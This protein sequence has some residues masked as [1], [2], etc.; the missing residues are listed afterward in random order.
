MNIS[1]PFTP[2][3]GI[4]DEQNITLLPK[5]YDECGNLEYNTNTHGCCNTSTFALPTQFC[6]GGTIYSKCGGSDYDPA[7]Q[8]CSAQDSE[9]YGKCGGSEYNTD[10][11][12]CCNA[13]IF[14]LSTQFCPGSTIYSKCGSSEYNTNTHG[15][16]NAATF[17]LPTQFCSG[18][19]IYS[20]CGGSDYDPA[21]QFCS[22]QDGE[23]YGKC[24]GSEYNT[25][26]HGCCNAEIFDL[27]T[28]FCPGSTIYSKCGSSEYN[29]NTHGCCNTSTFA[30]ATQFC[31]GSTIYSKC[32]GS[33]YNPAS[34]FCSAQDSEVYDKC[35]GS[36]YNT[37]T[38]GCCNAATFVLSTQ[39]CS[40]SGIYSKCGGNDY[41]PSAQYCSNGTVK[42][43][44]SVP[45]QGQTYKTVVIGT[46][47]WM[48]ENLNYNVL[49]S[50][51]GNNST[52]T[53]SDNN[54]S[55]CDIYGRL[56][57][58]ATAMGFESRCNSSFCSV[59]PKHKGIC[60]SGWHIPSDPEWT[61]L[62][63]YVGGSSAGTKL[64]ATGGWNS[65]G[66]GTDEYG[67][68]ALPGGA[69]YSDGRF[70]G[71]GV[72]D[73]WWSATEYRNSNA[74]SW[75]MHY[76]NSIVNRVCNDKSS[77]YSVRCVQD[78]PSL[79]VEPVK[80]TCGS[81][82]TTGTSGTAITPPALTCSNGGTPTNTYWSNNAPGWNNP[83]SGTYNN[84]SATATCGSASGLTANCS[85]SLSVCSAK[86]NTSTH[87]CSGGTM[88]TYGSVPLGDQTY[89][90]VVIG[91]Q[92]WMAENLNYNASGSKCY[93]NLG[94]NCNTYGR[95]YDWSTA[96]DLPSSCNSDFCSSQTQ[97][98]HRGI[99]PSGWHIPSEDD[100]SILM[101][102]VGGNATAGT[103]LKATSGWNSR[104]DGAYGNGTNN[105]GFS[106]LP[107]GYGP[108]DFNYFYTVG[109]LGYW[110]SS[111]EY[112]SNDA[113]YRTMGNEDDG[114]YWDYYYKSNLYSVRCLQD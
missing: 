4:N 15:C 93:D 14:D 106:A 68:S 50:K 48:A 2:L 7:S 16:C 66:N 33:D 79:E 9:V 60:P 12:G 63:G 55:T 32:G 39:F 13:E 110:W 23:V 30:L 29:T 92:T 85:G 70:D 34:Q 89:K 98:K 113:Y 83:A 69:G 42:T 59:Q 26:T 24:G 88:K 72:I 91:T 75:N 102:Y 36:N 47:T 43:Y 96:M 100:W 27:S 22:A 114:A 65:N 1:Y 11:H 84:I 21:S 99:C 87:Y 41:N 20:K 10:T 71:V 44:G 108:S 90:T 107:G 51:C 86:D 53:L 8:F 58:W 52:F 78:D 94:S 38:H 111:S 112:N 82:P 17:A 46:Q 31:S 95:L 81:V 97:S 56:Y 35:G 18:S 54:T 19:T 73:F 76:Y 80:L 45:Y 5:I 62:V 74:C 49:D 64:K 57:N 25:D 105:Y 67:F 28:Q 3:I 40:G 37:D 101:D 77:L 103:K 109:R 61:T 104:T 6:S